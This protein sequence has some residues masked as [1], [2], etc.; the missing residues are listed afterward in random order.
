MHPGKAVHS[1]IG[2]PLDCQPASDSSIDISE[3]CNDSFW[4]V[5]KSSAWHDCAEACWYSR[6]DL[7]GPAELCAAL[8]EPPPRG[9]REAE[10]GSDCSCW[11]RGSLRN[12][13][14]C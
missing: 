13:L 7:I 4:P 10:D 6:A 8:Q 11:V 3:R 9:R 14:L 5:N 1:R 2:L 12:G